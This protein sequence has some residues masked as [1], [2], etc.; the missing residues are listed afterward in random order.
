MKLPPVL[1]EKVAPT[2]SA[3]K[4]KVAS[5]AVTGPAKA[6]AEAEALAKAANALPDITL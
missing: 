4:A 6:R 5:E 1:V 3:A 2:D